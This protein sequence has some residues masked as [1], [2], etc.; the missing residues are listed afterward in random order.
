MKYI[1]NAE[2]MK[3]C[4]KAVIKNDLKKSL[5]LIDRAGAAC[6]SSLCKEGLDPSKT[7]IFCGYGNNGA[8]G[9]SIAQK[10]EKDNAVRIVFADKNHRLSDEGEYLRRKLKNTVITDFHQFIKTENTAQ[11]TLI[12]DALFGVGLSRNAEGIF[13]D[14]ID[15]INTAECEILSVDIPSGI[16]ADSGQVMG[17]AVK[18]SLTVSFAFEKRGQ[19]LY[20]GK[21]CCGK[22]VVAD[23]GIPA[24]E[25]ES[26]R[27]CVSALFNDKNH[28][29]ER[30]PYGNK[31]TFGKVLVVAG[32]YEIFG[33]AFLS[34]M[35]AYKSGCGMVHILTEQNNIQSL[36]IMLPEAILH[37]YD[38]DHADHALELLNGL[39]EICDVVLAGPGLGMSALSTALV[40]RILDV[41]KPVI[42]DADALNIVAKENYFDKISNG[43]FIFTPHVLEMSRLTGLSVSQI[44]QTFIGTAE[45]FAKKYD[46]VL[47]LKDAVSIVSAP[48]ERT[49]IN[50]TGNAAMAKAGSGDVLAGVI[51]AFAAQKMELFEAAALGVYIH[52]LA[53]D[54]KRKKLGEYSLLAR[55]LIEGIEELRNEY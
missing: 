34:A 7:L 26:E 40:S 36:Q 45:D 51:A 13:A 22:L 47:V 12:I 24:L 42:L 32:S 50:H 16:S 20:P 38:H 15:L 1:L 37:A 14:M 28:L 52:G 23:I 19:V 46:L 11:Y 10:L 35:A 44:K 6:V 55:N 8:D 25:E 48:R 39:L 27:Y 49:Y 33:A 4:D 54:M 5:E 30:S 41:K 31:G 3:A 43:N 18:A 21:L 29:P 9:I 53:G 2:Q 17:T